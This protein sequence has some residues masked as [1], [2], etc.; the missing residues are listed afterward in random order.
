MGVPIVTLAAPNCHAHN[1]SHTLL[2]S[3][4]FPEL[5][6]RSIPEYIEKSVSLANDPASLSKYRLSLREKM[7][8][9]VLMDGKRHTQNL[10]NA[11]GE[12][13]DKHRNQVQ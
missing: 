5:V 12:M 8:S 6:T 1:V 4:G 13:F 2:N 3:V 7:K 9:S 10:E 11:Y